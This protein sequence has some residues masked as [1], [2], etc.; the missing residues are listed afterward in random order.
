MTKRL[1]TES[2]TWRGV[3]R[4][5]VKQMAATLILTGLMFLS[6]GTLNW[7][8]G[9][10]YLGFWL[11]NLFWTALILVPWNPDLLGER[12]QLGEGVQAL[13]VVLATLMGYSFLYHIPIAGLDFR[14][15]WTENFPPGLML[16][17]VMTALAGSS[18]TLWA[19]AINRYFSGVVRIQL[20]R[21]HT[22]ITAGP[23]R[24]LRHP[25]YAGAI[26]FY[27]ASP[28]MLASWWLYIPV[29]LTVSVTFYRAALEDHRL[30]NELQ[31]YRA[32]AQQV[33]WRIVPG[34]W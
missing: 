9:R 25:G 11:L 15:A 3:V 19:M 27:L 33:R 29:A 10:V 2:K 13:D 5:A 8:G 20:E 32:Y 28:L 17:G 34:I 24:Y 22:V 18:L 26:L 21:G 1:R 7:P 16:V 30:Q 4:W 14:Y 23:Y 6:A 12:S 31:G